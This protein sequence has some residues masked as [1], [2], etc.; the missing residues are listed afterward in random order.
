MIWNVQSEKEEIFTPAQTASKA[1]AL[2]EQLADVA[3]SIRNDGSTTG[4]P[5]EL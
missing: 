4:V 2:D 5:V 3:S 1:F